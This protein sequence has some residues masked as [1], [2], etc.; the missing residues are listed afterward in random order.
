MG[1]FPFSKRTPICPQCKAYSGCHK[2]QGRPRG[3]LANEELRRLR[4]KVHWLFDPTWKNAGIQRED[5]YV[6][7]ARK[8][9]IPLHCCHIGLFDVELCQRAIKMLQSN[10]ITSNN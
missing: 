3:T 8:L 10:K 5:G 6:W 7:L 1:C 9:N 4:R 2:E